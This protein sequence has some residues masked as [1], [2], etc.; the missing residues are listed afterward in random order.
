MANQRIIGYRQFFMRGNI[1]FC[2]YH[3][4][5]RYDAV[6]ITGMVAE[7]IFTK[8]A[9]ILRFILI[10]KTKN[11]HMAVFYI[12][13]IGDISMMVGTMVAV[14][15]EAPAGIGVLAFKQSPLPGQTLTYDGYCGSRW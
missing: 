11:A 15:T 6:R 8:H 2:L 4:I 1:F 9:A 14:P 7:S 5:G 10:L 3:K 12:R 13:I